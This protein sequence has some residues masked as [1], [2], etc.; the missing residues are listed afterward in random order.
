MSAAEVGKSYY[1]G[2]KYDFNCC[3]AT[4]AAFRGPRHPSMAELQRCGGGRAPGGVC[5][6]VHA[7][8]LIRPDLEDALKAEFAEKAGAFTCAEIKAEGKLSCKDCVALGCEILE[9]NGEK[10]LVE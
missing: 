7:G 2:A 10:P 9:R 4:A 3:Q 8:R 5:G 6:A 1:H